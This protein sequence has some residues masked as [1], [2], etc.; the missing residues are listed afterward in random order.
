MDVN[1]VLKSTTPFYHYDDL[2]ELH[3]RIQL[4]RSGFRRVSGIDGNAVETGYRL[5]VLF[6]LTIWYAKSRLFVS[7]IPLILLVSSLIFLQTRAAFIACFV[8]V[9]LIFIISLISKDTDI[10]KKLK[11][12]IWLGFL[13]PFAFALLIF[14]VPLL[15]KIGSNF[16]SQSLLPVFTSKGQFIG[17]KIERIPRAIDYFFGK[18][19]TGYG[20]PQ[21]AYYVVME[22][23][24]VPG[25]LIYLLA[26]G[27]PLGLLYLI[28]LVY[29]PVSIFSMKK[30]KSL[31]VDQKQL[32]IYLCAAI[33]SGVIVVLSNSEEEHFPLMVMIY[34]AVFKVFGN[35]K[36]QKEQILSHAEILPKNILS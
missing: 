11:N 3:S 23:D 4:I 2:Y 28:F 36:K 1:A 15:Q 33:A 31:T 17:Q 25:P 34:I 6:P 16:F 35:E 32:L 24:D 21:Y 22:T 27:L 12:T 18:P 5:A 20:S 10:R 7:K 26:G 30:S 19:L 9:I 14:S 29:M 8:S 13:L